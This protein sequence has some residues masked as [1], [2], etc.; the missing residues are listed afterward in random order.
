MN[1]INKISLV[2]IICLISLTIVSCG[3]KDFPHDD[4]QIQSFTFLENLDSL[5]GDEIVHLA[6]GDSVVKGFGVE[7]GQNY[8]YLV[9]V[10]ISKA[11]GKKVVKINNG[12][13]GLTSYELKAKLESG[14]FD[15]QIKNANL[16]TLNIGGNDLLKISMDNGILEAAKKFQDTKEK[17]DENLNGIID[18]IQRINPDAKV[19]V[20]ELYNPLPTEHKFSSIAGKLLDSWN[21]S[22]YDVVEKKENIAVAKIADVINQADTITSDG[23]HP[24]ENGYQAISKEVFATLSQAKVLKN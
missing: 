3:Q 14:Q 22:I 24:N 1:S 6:L 12:I 11:T 16:I 10:R 2:G 20:L 13:N 15:E 17:F 5:K 23:V 4:K 9:S 18:H 7:D 21:G 19:V 8:V